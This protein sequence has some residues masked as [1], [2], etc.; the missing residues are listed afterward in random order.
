[1]PCAGHSRMID[2]MDCS[3]QE[4]LTMR[5]DQFCKYYEDHALHKDK[6]QLNVISLEFS[7]T[8]LDPLVEA[9]KVVSH[10]LH[11]VCKF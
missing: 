7:H 9:P 8:R 1:M 3:S 2:V 4:A 6:R 10:K 5:L 11:N